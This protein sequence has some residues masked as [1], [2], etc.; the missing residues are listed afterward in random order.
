M[1]KQREYG[2]VAKMKN[3][4]E[5]NHFSHFFYNNQT[6]DKGKEAKFSLSFFRNKGPC[7]NQ[8]QLNVGAK[9]EYLVLQ[10]RGTSKPE[11]PTQ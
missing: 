7:T 5:M 1:P 6:C 11:I 2:H 3:M 4:K 9:L 10:T 8:Q